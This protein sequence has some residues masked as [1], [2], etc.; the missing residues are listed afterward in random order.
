VFLFFE[1]IFYKRIA[2]TCVLMGLLTLFYL[3][4]F[5]TRH[6]GWIVSMAWCC[7]KILACIIKKVR[8]IG[9]TQ[10]CRRERERERKGQRGMYNCRR[11]ESSFWFGRYVLF[12]VFVS[13]C[14][15]VHELSQKEQKLSFFRILWTVVEWWWWC[16]RVENN[17]SVWLRNRE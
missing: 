12:G 16:V 10:I 7:N 1:R 11:K 6:N 5:P 15:F 3:F 17:Y 9:W 4:F 14:V 13:V 8:L 2:L